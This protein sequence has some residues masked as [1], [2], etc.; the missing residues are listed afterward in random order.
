LAPLNKTTRCHDPQY[1]TLPIQFHY[2]HKPYN[3]MPSLFFL[4]NIIVCLL[5]KKK[6]IYKLEYFICYFV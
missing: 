3:V 2:N 1:H 4:F 6:I 5:L